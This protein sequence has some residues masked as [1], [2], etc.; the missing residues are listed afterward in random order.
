MEEKLCTFCG[1]E[2]ASDFKRY[3]IRKGMESCEIFVCPDCL[4]KVRK[5]R[6]TD[7]SLWTKEDALTLKKMA[8]S[9]VKTV[10]K[11]GMVIFSTILNFGLWLI[12]Q[13]LKAEAEWADVFSQEDVE[14]SGGYE[15]VD[16]T[17]I[18]SF[19]SDEGMEGLAEELFEEEPPFRWEELEEE[20]EPGD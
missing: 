17:G 11:L 14:S 6:E 19:S 8:K 12:K 5:L 16:D 18:E 2:Y 4:E 10:G 20:T 3:T 15:V 13:G 7:K 1:K 9:T